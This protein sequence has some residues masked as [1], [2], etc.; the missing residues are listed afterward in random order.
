MVSTYS[1]QVCV[2]FGINDL[3]L[4]HDVLSVRAVPI[5]GCPNTRISGVSSWW[6][7]EAVS[8]AIT[9][10]EALT[11]YVRYFGIQ[12]SIN[13]MSVCAIHAQTMRSRPRANAW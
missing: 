11:G 6:N 5:F 9:S 13:R 2:F 1:L 8:R 7:K 3:L 12:L 4:I 10:V